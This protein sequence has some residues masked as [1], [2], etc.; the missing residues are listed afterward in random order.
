MAKRLVPI[1]IER[2]IL[3]ELLASMSR[4][5]HGHHGQPMFTV[6]SANDTEEFYEA[7]E[8]I[9]DLGIAQDCR[10]Q[11]QATLYHIF[12]EAIRSLR[13]RPHPTAPAVSVGG[14][15]PSPSPPHADDAP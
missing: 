15:G 13:T 5:I 4:Q 14:I 3:L 7:I 11:Y 10:K 1:E 2:K 6:K 12:S 9:R 8:R